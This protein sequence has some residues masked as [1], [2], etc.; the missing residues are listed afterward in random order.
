MQANPY[1]E[2]KPKNIQ[3]HHYYVKIK[4][5]QDGSLKIKHKEYPVTDKYDERVWSNPERQCF[6]GT[7]VSAVKKSKM[8]VS[9]AERTETAEYLHTFCE[10]ELTNEMQKK[11]FDEY[12]E[13]RCRRLKQEI[14]RWQEIAKK[15]KTP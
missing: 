2:R 1:K 5:E 11:I 13:D 10:K 9:F 6:E 12:I 15:V 4:A 14:W 7:Y 3:L 8:M